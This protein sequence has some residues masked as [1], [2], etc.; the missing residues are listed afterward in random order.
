MK[1]ISKIELSS[2]FETLRKRGTFFTVTFIKK[3][4]ST[5]RLT[6]RFGVTSKLRGGKCTVPEDKY[7][8]VYEIAKQE[9]RAVAKDTI[10]RLAAFNEVYTVGV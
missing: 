10:Q 4:G 6:G 5:R 2:L 8:I 9:Y 7:Y 1:T 3:D